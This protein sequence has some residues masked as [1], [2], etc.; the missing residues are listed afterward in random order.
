MIETEKSLKHIMKTALEAAMPK[1]KFKFI[2]D[3][4]AF[5]FI[6]FIGWTAVKL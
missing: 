3:S 5:N 2:P 1:D 4:F 6:L